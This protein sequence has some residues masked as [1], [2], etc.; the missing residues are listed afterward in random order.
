MTIDDLNNELTEKERRKKE[1]D[2]R[3]FEELKSLVW[4]EEETK[5]QK[6]IIEIFEKMRNDEEWMSIKENREYLIQLSETE[7]FFPTINREE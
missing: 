1:D 2:R 4:E 5:R 6:S 7:D 3:T